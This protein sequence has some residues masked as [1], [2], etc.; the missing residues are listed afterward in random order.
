MS[1]RCTSSRRALE[2]RELPEV[3]RAEP[4]ALR[5]VVQAVAAHA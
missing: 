5:E 3:R 1:V 2:R 4:G